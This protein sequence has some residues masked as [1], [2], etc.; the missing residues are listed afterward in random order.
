LVGKVC[1]WDWKDHP[2][3]KHN[4]TACERAFVREYRAI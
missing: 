3:R 4:V 2:H 1:L